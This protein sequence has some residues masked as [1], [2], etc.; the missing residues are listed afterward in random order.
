MQTWAAAG[1]DYPVKQLPLTCCSARRYSQIGYCIL[2]QEDYV[3]RMGWQE[4][5]ALTI[6]VLTAAAFVWGRFRPRKLSFQRARP[7]GCAA[8]SPSVSRGSIVFRARKG[9]RAEVTVRL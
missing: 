8:G 2:S 9:G 5:V 4:R 6:V 1:P 3:W 7:C